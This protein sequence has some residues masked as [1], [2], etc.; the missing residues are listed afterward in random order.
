[1]VESSTEHDG[2]CS[3]SSGGRDERL[4]EN[5]SAEG[6]QTGSVGVVIVISLIVSI[7]GIL[8]G[9]SHGFPSP[10]LLDLQLEY[11]RGDRVTAFSSSSNYVGLFGVR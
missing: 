3:H 8:G 9:Y 2:V 4:C 11:E 6:S 10:T 5:G 7:G 1:M